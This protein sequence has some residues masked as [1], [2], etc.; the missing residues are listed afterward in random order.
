MSSAFK[1]KGLGRKLDGVGAL[2]A[3]VAMTALFDVGMM[4]V[5]GPGPIDV[6]RFERAREDFLMA[7]ARDFVLCSLHDG[8]GEVASWNPLDPRAPQ[9]LEELMLE[10]AANC[11]NDRAYQVEIR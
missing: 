5:V 9:S 1:A 6:A 3:A 7:A 10:M 11:A 4:N 8:T 2:G